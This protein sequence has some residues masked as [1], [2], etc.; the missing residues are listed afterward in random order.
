MKKSLRL[1]ALLGCA[2]LVLGISTGKIYAR[3]SGSGS[4]SWCVGPSGAEICVDTSGNL[5][6]TTDNDTT[7][8]TS[9]LRFATAYVLDLNVDDDLTVT[10]RLTADGGL[11]LAI[12]T[13]SQLVLRS[14]AIGTQFLV[15]ERVAGA[16]VSNAYN[17]CVS[18][19]A[20]IASYVYLDVSTSAA[21]IAGE[22]CN[23]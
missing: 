16:L 19:A 15:Q 8:G 12:Q 13:T 10:D 2:I 17:T 18:T 3:V 21:A 4:D 23:K 7:L 9:A 11:D 6:P 20:N 22:A 14:D 5:L 1:L